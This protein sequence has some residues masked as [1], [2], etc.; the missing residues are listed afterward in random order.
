MGNFFQTKFV[1]K[2]KKNTFSC[3]ITLIFF[4][5]RAVYDVMW[6]NVLES[7]RPQMAT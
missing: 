6:I 1:E 3:S 2:L 5:N 7:G 4:E